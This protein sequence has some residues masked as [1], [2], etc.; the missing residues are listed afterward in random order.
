MF[1]ARSAEVGPN[2]NTKATESGLGAWVISA[3][4]APSFQHKAKGLWLAFSETNSPVP[5]KLADG[6]DS[7]DAEWAVRTGDGDVYQR[8][9]LNILCLD[10]AAEGSNHKKHHG[11]AAAD[12]ASG[13]SLV[14]L[15]KVDT[16]LVFITIGVIGVV[17]AVI[18]IILN[19]GPDA[20]SLEKKGRSDEEML[21][22]KT[23]KEDAPAYGSA[24]PTLFTQH[25]AHAKATSAGGFGLS[26]RNPKAFNESAG[27]AAGAASPLVAGKV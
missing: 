16:S 23:P 21:T 20:A 6:P 9:P 27:G 4:S 22:M 26:P 24:R 12:L 3:L 2:S 7:R 5:D 18:A 13:T 10:T 14:D 8:L 17:I 25:I 1:L 15:I 19:S 11:H